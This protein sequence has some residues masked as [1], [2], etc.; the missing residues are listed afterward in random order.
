MDITQRRP[1]AVMALVLVVRKTSFPITGRLFIRWYIVLSCRGITHCVALFCLRHVWL[2]A[3]P[4]VNG[5]Y[6]ELDDGY[7]GVF[8]SSGGVVMEN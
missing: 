3:I 2:S 7:R 6:S 1:Q 4:G 8:A 5:Q